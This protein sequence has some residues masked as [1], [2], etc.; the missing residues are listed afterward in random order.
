MTTS[1]TIL[2]F[3]NEQLATGVTTKLPILTRLVLNGYKVSAIIIPSRSISN[4]P[5]TL[6]PVQLF[7]QKHDIPVIEVTKL[8]DC[9]DSL[10]QFQPEIGI[11]AA[12]GRIIP[13]ALID[14]FPKGIVN[15][16]PS[17]LPAH[18]GPTP[19]E[20]TILSG[21]TES[22]ISLMRLVSNMDAG[23]IFSQLKIKLSGKETKQALA[24]KLGILGA[25]ELIRLLPAILDGTL[26]PLPQSTHQLS[27]DQRLSKQDSLLDFNKPAQ[28]LEREIRA[29]QGWPRSRTTINQQPVI[30]TQ[31]KVLIRPH[32]TPCKPQVVNNQLVIDTTDNALLV[33]RLIPS[34]SKEMTGTEYLLGH[35]L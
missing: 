12:F 24:D 26:S 29:Y 31:G 6:S 20:S 27:Y 14:L 25:D 3:G 17:L 10:S 28:Q 4:H 15:L 2:F 5:K 11:L 9:L 33:E 32:T 35:K 19:I 18:R 30:I 1:K 13:Q 7:A 8:A 21:A 34:G 16:H 22:G 23:P